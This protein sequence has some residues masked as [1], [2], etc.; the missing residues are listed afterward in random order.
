MRFNIIF[1]GLVFTLSSFSQ[2]Y[3]IKRD[4]LLNESYTIEKKN[5]NYTNP[6]FYN[7]NYE[8][9]MFTRKTT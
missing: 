5:D 7:Y 4:N 2:T 8:S 3:T 1:F 9:D 6:K